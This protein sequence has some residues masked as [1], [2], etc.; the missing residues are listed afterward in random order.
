M[1]VWPRYLYHSVNFGH[2]GLVVA[3]INLLKRIINKN[4]KNVISHTEIKATITLIEVKVWTTY[5]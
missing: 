5:K 1:L 2:P 4:N 3:V